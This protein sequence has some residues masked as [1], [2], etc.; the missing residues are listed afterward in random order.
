M[1]DINKLYSLWREKATEKE[2]LDELISVEGNEKEILDR[3]WQNL[4][5]GTGGLRGVIGAYSKE[6]AAR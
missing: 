1:N 2:V 3:F 5:F 4:A 6:N